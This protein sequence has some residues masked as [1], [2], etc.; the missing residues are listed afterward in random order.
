MLQGSPDALKD[1]NIVFLSQETAERYFGD[2]H[3]AMENP[4][5]GTINNHEGGRGIEKQPA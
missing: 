3:K 4:S 1:P 5:N 2:W